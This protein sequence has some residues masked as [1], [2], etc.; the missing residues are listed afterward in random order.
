[1]EHEEISGHSVTRCRLMNVC[2][3]QGTTSSS[4]YNLYL[5]ELSHLVSSLHVY[6]ALTERHQMLYFS[7]DAAYFQ[8]I[9]RIA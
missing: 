1:M 4:C 7:M 9:F 8:T 3:V 6:Q 5:V 2:K